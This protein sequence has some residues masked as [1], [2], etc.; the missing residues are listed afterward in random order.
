MIIDDK[1]DEDP[2]P[3]SDNNNTTPTKEDSIHDTTAMDT[4][5]ALCSPEA[6]HTPAAPAS[7]SFFS[8]A[9]TSI[10]SP[11]KFFIGSPAKET[12]L[13]AGKKVS[14]TKK[15]DQKPSLKPDNTLRRQ[16][17]PRTPIKSTQHLESDHHN[18][19]RS[20]RFNAVTPR[21]DSEEVEH[22]A[23]A[24]TPATSSKQLYFIYLH[25]GPRTR[26]YKKWAALQAS[27][28]A[29]ILSGVTET[30]VERQ[31]REHLEGLKVLVEQAGNHIKERNARYKAASATA[32]V[33]KSSK[34]RNVE[35]TPSTEG[36]P[37]KKQRLAFEQQRTTTPP[38]VERPVPG[39]QGYH[40]STQLPS[41]RANNWVSKSVRTFPGSEEDD[42]SSSS[43][44]FGAGSSVPGAS[45]GSNSVSKTPNKPERQRSQG[46]TFE[47]PSDDEGDTSDPQEE[48]ISREVPV[49]SQT[50][51][52][53]FALNYDEFSESEDESME[54]AATWKGKPFNEWTKSTMAAY[55]KA[56][57]PSGVAPAE[58]SLLNA[59]TSIIAGHC[60]DP[61]HSLVNSSDHPRIAELGMSPDDFL[62]VS[63]PDN[64]GVVTYTRQSYYH[65]TV[66]PPGTENMN[67]QERATWKC[68]EEFR[69]WRKFSE[70]VRLYQQD[71]TPSLVAKID[72]RL[73]DVQKKRK[74]I[75]DEEQEIRRKEQELERRNKRLVEN[76][77]E[78]DRL[79]EEQLQKQ[80][81][82]AVMPQP[83]APKQTVF[84]S[85]M[86]DLE[87]QSQTAQPGPSVQQ[88]A[89]RV[90]VP[91]STTRHTGQAPLSSVISPQNPP[92][93]I[94]DANG[95][96]ILATQPGAA[97]S[98]TA[99]APAWTQSPPPAP[100]P[101]HAQLPP[102]AKSAQAP[103]PATQPSN[104][105]APKKPS[106]L[107][108]STTYSPGP[109]VQQ[110]IEKN[111]DWRLMIPESQQV[112]SLFGPGRLTPPAEAEY[113][114]VEEGL[115]ALDALM[116]SMRREPGYFG[117]PSNLP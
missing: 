39:E 97:S 31:N 13:L 69:N 105:Y 21:I 93:Y 94:Y 103:A 85:L 25:H 106:R 29:R 22:R 80:K 26:F 48:S 90:T 43:Q 53:T 42:T 9:F 14:A 54:D 35:T 3:E 73:Q 51:G 88:A 8:R 40:V 50:I 86:T 56:P 59:V 4:S 87:E 44:V 84:N 52:K 46:R 16:K 12:S 37:M 33:T 78:L 49:V 6:S 65:W 77:K 66:K 89:A 30:S 117:G 112:G 83:A 72:G 82:V 111:E 95:N 108:E 92:P 5:D 61:I 68:M 81:A 36:S 10:A 58:Q 47:V 75:E 7:T 101:A 62:T 19:S 100:T 15:F 23:S 116:P 113:S 11:I 74:R 67:N 64:R 1:L 18:T 57:L 76:E 27:E 71:D 45:L 34:K 110:S 115:K 114:G 79:R 2:S 38:G 104:K 70:V 24:Q 107:R 17:L 20:V 60:P 109:N 32:S 98:T 63:Y 91:S 41:T 102:Q 28:K 55:K 99:S 96:A